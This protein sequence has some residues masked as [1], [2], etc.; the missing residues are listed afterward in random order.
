MKLIL[1]LLIFIGIL[2]CK[3]QN[4]AKP[5]NVIGIWAGKYAT[6]MQYTTIDQCW[7]IKENGKFIVY[8]QVLSPPSIR[9]PDANINDTAIGSYTLIGKKINAT[10]TFK[11]NGQPG[12]SRS[13]EATISDD[14]KKIEGIK[15]FPNS[16]DIDSVWMERK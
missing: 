11:H 10:Y 13:I 7:E 15:R 3:K 14:L 9:T 16:T 4:D 5:V 8:D 2:S 12:N 6:S 1:S